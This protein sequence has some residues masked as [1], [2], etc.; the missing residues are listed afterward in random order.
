MCVCAQ[1]KKINNLEVF[2]KNSLAAIAVF[3]LISVNAMA[4]RDSIL[5]TITVLSTT[6]TSETQAENTYSYLAKNTTS[7]VMT[8]LQGTGKFS[9]LASTMTEE[10]NVAVGVEVLGYSQ[11][12]L[13]QAEGNKITVS[14]DQNL[15]ASDANVSLNIAYKLQS[16]AEITKGTWE[17]FTQGNEI[18]F[19]LTQKSLKEES[20]VQ[21]KNFSKQIEAAVKKGFSDKGIRASVDSEVDFDEPDQSSQFCKATPSKLVCFSAK[22]VFHVKMNV[23]GL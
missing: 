19:R 9:V 13:R 14:T 15:T 12:I 7:S 21:A 6:V 3:T 5:A 16:E 20:K 18:E 1:N 22:D 10:K 8:Q 4:A 17:S 23:R 11:T 2:V